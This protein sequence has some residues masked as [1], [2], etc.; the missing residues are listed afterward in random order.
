MEWR[1]SPQSSA[2]AFI[3][4]GR[5]RGLQGGAPEVDIC[6]RTCKGKKEKGEKKTKN[7]R[8]RCLG[9]A[10]DSGSTNQ[11]TRS[12]VLHLLHSLNE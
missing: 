11:L 1:V 2:G 7:L 10:R 3:E 12:K 8:T 5:R 6:Q 9:L 4:R